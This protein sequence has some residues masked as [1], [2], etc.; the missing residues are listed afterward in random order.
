MV[1]VCEILTETDRSRKYWSDLKL[2]LK[3]E[4]SELSDK[5]GQLKMQAHDR[6]MRMTD[7][8]D[9]EQLSRLIQT[10]LSKGVEPF[11]LWLA[12]VE[13]IA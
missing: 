3:S 4:G 6:K 8:L 11:E 10:I 9:T 13:V 1:D 12:Q 2:K 5:I 7:V